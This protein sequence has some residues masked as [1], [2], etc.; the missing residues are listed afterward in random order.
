[1]SLFSKVTTA[2]VLC[3]LGASTAMAGPAEDTLIAKIVQAY[4]GERLT[5]AKSLRITNKNK[6]LAVGQSADP[7]VLDIGT[8]NLILTIDFENERK[9]FSQWNSN[10]AGTFYNQTIVDGDTKANFNHIQKIRT[11]NEN[12]QYAA[13]G[14][15]TMRT[16]DTTLVYLMLEQQESAKVGE[17]VVIGGIPHQTLTFPMAGS[18]DL[19]IY[20]NSDTS[21][22]SR[23]T[24][25]NPQFGDLSYNFSDHQRAGGIVYAT[26]ANFQ[27]AGQPNIFAVSRT[28]EVN[29]GIA[30]DFEIPSGYGS[31]GATLD[32]SE[33]QVRELGNGIY[34]AGLNG[35]FSVFVDAGDHFVASGGYAGLTE[36]F[37]AVKEAAGVDKPLSYQV[38]THHHSD[39][40]GGIPEA[41][42][43]N[44]NLVTVESHV[45][46]LQAGLP[47]NLDAERFRIVDGRITLADGKMEVY[48]ISTVHSDHNLLVYL[49]EIDLVFSADHFSTNLEEGLP[50]ANRNMT[51]FR[52]AVESLSLDI[53]GFL[54]AHGTR[55]LTMEDL[56]DATDAYRET[57]CP[58][59]NEICS[60]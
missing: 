21:L 52:K 43:L 20:V 49:P 18:P 55:M 40:I 16:V 9:S 51:S 48:D 1:M 29:S 17:T 6:N 3:G 10:R 56:R 15:G 58:T 13:V 39:H 36:R 57:E 45:A 28:V 27:I 25:N 5:S 60:N 34:Y 35:G 54:G 11:D 32:T 44:A 53:E 41:V 37:D 59:G 7:A 14:A 47:S 4:G 30:E 31:A 23:M 33:M 38:V 8:N 42:E 50:P 26:E 12:L 19:T 46:P 2:A 24:R 22:L